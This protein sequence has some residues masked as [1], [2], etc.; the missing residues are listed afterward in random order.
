LLGIV[1]ERVSGMKYEEYIALNIF[2]PPG[3]NSSGFYI[4]Y[5]SQRHLS[6]A[7]DDKGNP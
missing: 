2:E 3:M 7:F 5:D 6:A 1:I 4:D